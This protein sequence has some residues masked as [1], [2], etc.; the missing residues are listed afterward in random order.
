MPTLTSPTEDALW[1]VFQSLRRLVRAMR[2]YSRHSEG[3]HGLSMAQLFVLNQL[4]GEGELSLKQL[5]SASLTDPSSVSVVA[6]RLSTKGL[7]QRRP[8]PGDR[9][10][11]LFQL[12]PEGVKVLAKTGL[13]PQDV[14]RAALLSLNDEE[15]AVLDQLLKKVIGAAGLGASPATPFFEEGR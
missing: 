7:I 15:R 11:T 4:R 3:Q 8:A 13:P 5:A 9:R 2:I 14:L 6:R 10:S 12:S 1:G